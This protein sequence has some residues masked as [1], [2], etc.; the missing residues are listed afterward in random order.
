MPPSSDEYDL[1]LLQAMAN[2]DGRALEELYA[3]HGSSLLNFILGQISDRVLAEEILQNVMLAAWNAAPKFRGES[4]VRTWLF[5]IA[6]N[7]CINTYRKRKLTKVPLREADSVHKTG[8][9]EAIIMDTERAQ[10]RNAIRQLPQEQRDTLE[11]IFYHGLTG[12]EAAEILDVSVGTIKSRLHRAKAALKDLLG[13]EE[14]NN[15]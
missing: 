12:P 13:K 3:Q 4:K 6:R 1:M 8:P 7:Q 2:G 11:L 5:A 10:V 14:R 9:M 15:G